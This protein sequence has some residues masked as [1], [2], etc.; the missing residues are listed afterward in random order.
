MIGLNGQISQ[1]SD[2]APLVIKTVKGVVLRLSD[3]ATVIDGVANTRLAA[4]NGKQPAIL[5]TI[6]KSAGA[7]VIETVDHIKELLPQLMEWLPANIQLTVISDRTTT[8]RA[9]VADVQYTMMI[10]IA[11]VLLVVL[12][13]MRRLVPTIAAAVTVPLSI[14]RRSRRHEQ[15]GLSARQ[16]LALDLALT[17]SRWASWWTSD[18]DDREH[19]PP[20]ASAASIR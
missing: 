17:I 9:S 19:H 10:T 11:L 1:A 15:H 2:Y 4:W 5:L 12:V 14:M 6:T 3:V 18:R 8:I 16:L 7:N 20:A 13:F